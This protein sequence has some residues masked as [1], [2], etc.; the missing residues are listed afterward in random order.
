VNKKQAILSHIHRVTD[1]S[2]HKRSRWILLYNFDM[3]LILGCRE[4]QTQTDMSFNPKPLTVSLQHLVSQKLDS[5]ND[6]HLIQ[7]SSRCEEEAG[8]RRTKFMMNGAILASN[9]RLSVWTPPS[10]LMTNGVC[11]ASVLSCKRAHNKKRAYDHDQQVSWYRCKT[12]RTEKFSPSLI[13]TN[14]CKQA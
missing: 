10:G 11:I 2:T 1:G 7:D 13:K 8:L 9:V 14:N 6:A 3:D 12:K 5:E 4:F